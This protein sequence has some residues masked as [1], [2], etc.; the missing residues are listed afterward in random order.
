MAW[1]QR[2]LERHQQPPAAGPVLVRLRPWSVVLRIPTE[3]GSPVWFKA[4]PPGSAF[5][6]GLAAELHRL[7]PDCTLAPIA[8]D[9]SR[10]WSLMPH[11]GELLAD[12]APPAGS[13]VRHWEQPLRRYAELQRHLAPQS[14]AL[15]DLGVP[16][17]RPLIL[18]ERAAEVLDSQAAPHGGKTSHRDRM[19]ERLDRLCA[20]LAAT[21]VPSSLDHGDLH[22]GQ[23]LVGPG[24]RHTYFDW[25]DARVTHPFMSFVTTA[26]AIRRHVREADVPA[27]LTSARSA[28]LEPWTGSG[29][30]LG[31]LRAALDTACAAA[32]IVETLA[33]GRIF[34]GSGGS[35]GA[36]AAQLLRCLEDLGSA[37]NAG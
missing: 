4:N 35:P 17:L 28:Y 7:A 25:G 37:T 22:E 5:E 34:P 6:P 32:P 1:I 13:D 15:I 20:A 12:A 30:S 23:V 16:D 2:E 29:S 26:R 21:D 27:A 36:D 3:S 9:I 14:G 19:I 11:G 33:S 10:A 24:F 18:Q 31:E 8:V